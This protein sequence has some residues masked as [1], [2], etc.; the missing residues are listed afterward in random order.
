MGSRR[1]ASRELEEAERE[2]E[3]R[4]NE[5]ASYLVQLQNSRGED[6]ESLIKFPI[7]FQALL[8]SL[9]KNARNEYK[10]LQGRPRVCGFAAWLMGRHGR[11]DAP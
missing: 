2:Q 1:T 6:H 4:R 3:E 10:S 9:L 7:G 5:L 11:F 8:H